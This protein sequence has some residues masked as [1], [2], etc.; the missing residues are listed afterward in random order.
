MVSDHSSGNS[1]LEKKRDAQAFI[2]Y[3]LLMSVTV[4]KIDMI[5]E[6]AKAL[7]AKVIYNTTSTGDLYIIREYTLDRAIDGDV[8]E[9]KELKKKKKGD[10]FE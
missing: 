5:R 8:S 9:L 6:A 4:D 3:G 2:S 10:E 1:E 7:G